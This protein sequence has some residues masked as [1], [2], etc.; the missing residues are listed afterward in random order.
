MNNVIDYIKWR[1]DIS[2]KNDPFNEIDALIIARFAYMDLEGIGDNHITV[3]DAYDKYHETQNTRKIVIEEDRELF[4]VMSESVR[5]RDIELD[6]YFS[7]VDEADTRQ[8]SAVTLYIR[9][10]DISIVAFRGTDNTLIGWKEDFML[11][12]E[13]SISSHQTAAEYLDKILNHVTSDIIITGHSKGGHLA[14]VS[15]ILSK[16]DKNRI[17]HIYA[18]DAP[19]LPKTLFEHPEYNRIIDSITS[20]IPQTSIVGKMLSHKENTRII[21]STAMGPYQHDIYSWEILGKS[22]IY[23][24]ETTIPSEIIDSTFN[25]YL[26]SLSYD[27]RKTVIESM[28]DILEASGSLTIKELSNDFFGNMKRMIDKGKSLSPESRE[29]LMKAVKILASSMTKETISQL[30]ESIKPN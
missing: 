14:I 3:K 2:F 10:I 19:G 11:T 4:R 5:F 23:L 30:K 6:D 8:I 7:I 9:D 13:D 26:N 28:F 20:Y 22:F 27:D 29:V 18:F 25:D 1:G 12:F 24:K 21:S 15:G 16:G 17:R